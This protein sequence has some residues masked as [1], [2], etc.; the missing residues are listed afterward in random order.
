MIQGTSL[1]TKTSEKLTCVNNDID[2]LQWNLQTRDTLRL[3]VLSFVE[4]LS[5]SQRVPYRRFHCI[6]NALFLAADDY[7]SVDE[8]RTFLPGTPVGTEQC[9]NITIVDDVME[10]S[11]ESFLVIL[12]SS[13]ADINEDVA[14][15]IILDDDE[16]VPVPVP[17]ECRQA[18]TKSHPDDCHRLGGF[19]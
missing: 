2:Q 14:V 13:D 12:T 5:L 17:G 3:I 1:H 19:M 10:E 6:L 4:R 16:D 9:F 7:N 18:I 15:V 8:Q 11:D